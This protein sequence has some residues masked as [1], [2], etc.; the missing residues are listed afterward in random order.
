MFIKIKTKKLN[1]LLFTENENWQNS[2]NGAS[3]TVTIQCVLFFTDNLGLV[4]VLRDISGLLGIELGSCQCQ[5]SALP[6]SH[7]LKPFIT[8]FEISHY[9]SN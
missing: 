9:R 3:D 4:N 8:D 2:E 7:V 5:T 1:H 6:L